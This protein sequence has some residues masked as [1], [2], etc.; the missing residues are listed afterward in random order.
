MCWLSIIIV[1]VS[2]DIC[3]INCSMSANAAK[4]KRLSLNPIFYICH[5]S[6]QLSDNFKVRDH[7]QVEKRGRAGPAFQNSPRKRIW[8]ALTNLRQNC[9]KTSIKELHLFEQFHVCA[10]H[11]W[12]SFT[13]E[14]RLCALLAGEKMKGNSSIEKFRRYTDVPNLQYYWSKIPSS[15]KGYVNLWA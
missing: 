9:C 14:N 15:K 3:I 12:K 5:Q 10:K 4:I 11:P 1:W 2:S 13:S 7:L 8:W 6:L